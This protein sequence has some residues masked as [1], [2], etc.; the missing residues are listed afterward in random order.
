MATPPVT[1]GTVEVNGGDLH[2]AEAG[3]P[4]GPPVLLLH[5]FPDSWLLWRHQ[6]GTLAAAGHRVLAPDLRGFG[7]SA[8]PGAVEAYRMRTLVALSE[9][10]M[11]GS[12]DYVTGPWRYER[13]QGIDHWVPV[14][15][16]DQLSQLLVEFLGTT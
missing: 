4:D 13:L 1:E 10:R 6:V 11:T 7:R 3:P 15:A 12:A 16:P 2:L 8:R 14:H 5:G 9:A